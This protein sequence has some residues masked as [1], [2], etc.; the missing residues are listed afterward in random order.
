[1]TELQL[2]L[3]NTEVLIKLAKDGLGHLYAQ[4]KNKKRDKEIKKLKNFKKLME[5]I[6]EEILKKMNEGD[7]NVRQEGNVQ[8]N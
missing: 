6:K 2:D 3:K 1:M 8:E 5:A 4:K 7:E